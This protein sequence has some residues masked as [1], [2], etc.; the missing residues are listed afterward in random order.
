MTSRFSLG[1]NLVP[2]LPR[3]C[4]NNEDL[5]EHGAA[6]SER[7]RAHRQHL[8][9]LGGFA[10]QDRAAIGGDD[11]DELIENSVREGVVS[12]GRPLLLLRGDRATCRRIGR[13]FVGT[14]PCIDNSA[15][16]ILGSARRRMECTAFSKSPD[17]CV[18]PMGAS[19]AGDEDTRV[20]ASHSYV[21]TVPIHSS[22]T[23]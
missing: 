22:R 12:R 11:R 4:R 1:A 7:S 15:A 9:A 23:T 5:A 21:D 20:R 14:D 10:E 19:P 13:Q 2:K 6:D 18:I 3:A 16:S 8:D 17:G